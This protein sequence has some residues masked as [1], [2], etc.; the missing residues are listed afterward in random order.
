MFRTKRTKTVKVQT[1]GLVLFFCLFLAPAFAAASTVGTV[2]PSSGI[3]QTIAPISFKSNY[4]TDMDGWQ[5][6]SEVCLL[7]N[8]SATGANGVYVYYNQDTNLLYLRN[9]MDTGWVGGYVPGSANV[10]QNS[11]ASLDCSKSS[12]S[13]NNT[14]VSVT[15]NIALKPGFT[16]VKN[17]YS[18]A[19]DDSNASTG[20][21][22]K[23][24]LTVQEGSSVPIVTDDG[25]YTSSTTALNATWT[26]STPN[27][28]EYQY[29]VGSGSAGATNIKTWTS[30]TT[31][32][33]AYVSGLSLTPGT[34][35]YF[36]VKAKDN[37]GVWSAI[38]SSNGITVDKVPEICTMTPIDKSTFTEADNVSVYACANFWG[39]DKQEFQVSVNNV[40]VKPW[41]ESTTSCTCNGSGVALNYTWQPTSANKGIQTISV[42]A[43]D[44]RVAAVLKYTNVFV[45]RKAKGTP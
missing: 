9:D 17:E 8:A 11:R 6:L 26:I 13:P 41:A 45:F 36:N 15:W 35:Y 7:I 42:W 32:K 31:Y 22:Q 43:R 25:K 44:N 24:T 3:V 34:T 27:I 37:L 33:Y 18:S 28:T 21:V 14:I 30:T 40:V 38:G 10:I 20:W 16:G 29:S 12:I 23:G 39:A 5:N 1:L 4:Y 19:K 2:S